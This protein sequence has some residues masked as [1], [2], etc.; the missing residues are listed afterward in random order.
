[1]NDHLFY[2]TGGYVY[3]RYCVRTATFETLGTHYYTGPVGAVAVPNG[4][5][6]D[7]ASIPRLLRWKYDKVG[8][9][10]RAA[11]YH[12]ELYREQLGSR[13]VADALFL[14]WMRD[15]GVDLLTRWTLYAGVR[16]GGWWFWRKAG[17]LKAER[18]AMQAMEPRREHEEWLA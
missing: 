2:P 17:R 16:L 3:G 5:Q 14:E 10:L 11:M 4:R 1:M 12:D 7:F 6:T 13:A 9:Y 15:D 8:P 18:E